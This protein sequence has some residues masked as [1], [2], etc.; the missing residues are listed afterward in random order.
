MTES[1]FGGR[2][3]I[4]ILATERMSLGQARLGARADAGRLLRATAAY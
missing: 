3:G 2:V 4:Q 1:S